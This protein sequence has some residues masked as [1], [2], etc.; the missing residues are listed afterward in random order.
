MVLQICCSNM[1]SLELVDPST[2]GKSFAMPAIVATSAL[3]LAMIILPRL[4][5]LSVNG[6]GAAILLEVLLA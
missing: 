5:L 1:A 3:P 6:L 4:M 2:F